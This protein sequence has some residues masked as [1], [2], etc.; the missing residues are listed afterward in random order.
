MPHETTNELASIPPAI[1]ST[2]AS[3]FG[4][5]L[6][7]AWSDQLT[8]RQL[9]LIILSG[10]CVAV[11]VPPFAVPWVLHK[12]AVAWLPAAPWLY[13]AAGFICGLIG[14]KVVAAIIVFSGRFPGMADSAADRI[15]KRGQE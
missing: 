9:A 4:I 15:N 14:V 1:I 6:L 5:G 11:L 7:V 12:W 3:L 10:L 8:L 2:G 13:S